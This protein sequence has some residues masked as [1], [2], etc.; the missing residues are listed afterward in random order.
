MSYRKTFVAFALSLTAA[1]ASPAWAEFSFSVDGEVRLDDNIG[2][3]TVSADEIDDTTFRIAGNVNWLATQTAQTEV[4]FGAGIYHDRVSDLDDL[5]RTGFTLSGNYRGQANPELTSIFWLLDGNFRFF[6]YDDSDIRDGYEFKINGALG[7]RFNERFSA[8][9]GYRFDK[10]VSTDD[11]PDNQPPPAWMWNED[12]VFDLDKDGWFV[13]GEV[14][15]TPNT[16]FFVEYSD[17]S[18]DVAATGRSF[19]NGAMFDRAWD[20]A[21][22]QGFIVWKIDADQEI[23]DIGVSHGFGENLSVE[24]AA[25]FLDAQGDTGNDYEN[26]VFTF[27]ASYRF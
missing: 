20:W 15:V 25:S 8:M 22:G 7:K 3:G 1:L 12:D 21:F 17:L 6:E 11:N 19:N 23:W 18:G 2:F 10:R 13:R 14:D 16:L 9:V 27:S 26:Q 5:S 4:S 24:V